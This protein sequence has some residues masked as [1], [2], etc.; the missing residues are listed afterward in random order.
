DTIME[1]VG[2]RVD[3]I[4]EASRPGDVRDSL[5]DISRARDAFGYAPRYT[6]TEGLKETIQW[7][8]RK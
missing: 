1:I 7:F 8:A 5:A 6:I 3:P 2:T 4:H